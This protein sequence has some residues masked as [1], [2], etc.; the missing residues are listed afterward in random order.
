MDKLDFTDIKPRHS[1]WATFGA[2]LEVPTGWGKVIERML[3]DI[4]G[5]LRERGDKIRINAIVHSP[6]GIAVLWQGRIPEPDRERIAQVLELARFRSQATCETC[7]Q[8]GHMHVDSTRRVVTFRCDAHASGGSEP[9]PDREI[10]EAWV[11]DK[12][13]GKRIYHPDTDTVREVVL[14]QIGRSPTSKEDGK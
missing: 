11:S 4:G 2:K 14:D 1:D 7:G 13:V 10:S 3:D 9:V 8:R 6:H 12:Q 5:I